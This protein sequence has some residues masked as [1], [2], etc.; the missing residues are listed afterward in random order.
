M[1]TN[2]WAPDALWFGHRPVLVG[3]VE[4]P[5]AEPLIPKVR[6]A[7]AGYPYGHFG[8]YRIWPGP[9]SNTFVAHVLRAVPETG[10]AMPAAA[11]GKDWLPAGAFLAPAPSGT[12]WQVSLFGLIGAT[13]AI[14]EGFELDVL[15]LTA[16]LDWRHPAIKLPGWGRIGVARPATP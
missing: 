1:K 16:G 2:N 5:A 11:V 14:E 12:G 13:V 3:A 9:N 4:G 7:V 15:G 6:A 8:G 10:I